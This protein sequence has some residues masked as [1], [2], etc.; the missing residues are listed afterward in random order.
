[1]AKAF[2]DTPI[3][4]ITLRKF[5][6]PL[7]ESYDELLRRFCKSIG[8][9]QVGDSRD[10]IVD[11]LDILV[12]SAKSRRIVT[13]KE[14]ESSLPRKEKGLAPSNI[15]RQLSRLEKFGIVEKINKG[16]RIREFMSLEELLKE[17]VKPFIIDP[18]FERILEYAKKIDSF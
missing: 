10:I 13:A 2:R 18:T 8:L 4:E 1:M 16:Y 12:K 3:S 6:R 14:L 17:Y 5:E 15:R 11:I 7:S 9:L